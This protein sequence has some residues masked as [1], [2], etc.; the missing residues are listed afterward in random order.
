[1]VKRFWKTKR[2][3]N[4]HLPYFLFLDIRGHF[5]AQE[6]G[7]NIYFLVYMKMNHSD[8]LFSIFDEPKTLCSDMIA[9]SSNDH[10]TH[11][12]C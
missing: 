1:M 11:L 5:G 3:K 4:V 12:I 9:Y 8:L 2:V 6:K 7:E 10:M